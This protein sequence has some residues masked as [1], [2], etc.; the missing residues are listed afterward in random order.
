MPDWGSILQEINEN[1]PDPS[2]PD[3]VRRKYLANLCKYTERDV[4]LYASN[5]TQPTPFA[6]LVHINEEDVQG[7]MVAVHG[8]K[9][10][11]LDL[12]L[13]SPG[14]VPEVAE[15]MVSYLRKK[16][17]HIRVIVPQAAMSA[18]TMLACAA[19]EIVMGKQSSLGPI[20]PQLV[21]PNRHGLAQVLPVQAI[22]DNFETAKKTSVTSPQQMGAFLPIL[23]QYTPGLI[24]QCYEAQKLST[25][26]AS[27]WLKQYMFKNDDNA[28]EKADDIADRLASHSTFKSHAGHINMDEAT[29]LGLKV[30]PLEA[31]QQLQDLVLSAFHATT[32]VFQHGVL[33]II[34]NHLGKAFIKGQPPM[35]PPV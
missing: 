21:L 34:E 14:G 25:E 18:A 22:I 19:D 3:L 15:N 2:P 10:D 8:L 27:K 6:E 11:K 12:I 1:V 26:L 20:D 7:L 17:D 29:K 16:F 28:D 33:K 35:P 23:E 31:D 32:I 30:V 24:E 4:I 13:H 5:W 9:S